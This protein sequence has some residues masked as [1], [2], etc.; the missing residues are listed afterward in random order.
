MM[1]KENLP[2][3]KW[4][5]RFRRGQW[6]RLVPGVERPDDA[7]TCFA[8]LLIYQ[9]RSAAAASN[10]FWC[11]LYLPLLSLLAQQPPFL[12]S[13]VSKCRLL[14]LHLLHPADS[15]IRLQHAAP[16]L[17]PATTSS[18]QS[19]TPSGLNQYAWLKV[20]VI[21]TRVVFQEM[22]SSL[23]LICTWI[24]LS[25]DRR[26]AP[27]INTLLRRWQEESLP[28]VQ[29]WRSKCTSRPWYLDHGDDKTPTRVELLSRSDLV[30]GHF[31]YSPSSHFKMASA[32]SASHCKVTFSSPNCVCLR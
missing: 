32:Y 5:R 11:R 12:Y 17:L 15:L 16:S 1:W 29:D 3:N 9:A 8:L 2:M 19:S 23:V 28:E 26:W 10:A 7:S 21:N 25:M 14:S 18:S 22:L 31:P 27:G 24:V 6:G 30:G 20:S 13:N 4:W